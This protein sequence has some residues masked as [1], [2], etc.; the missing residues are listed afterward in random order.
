M[1]VAPLVVR[2]GLDDSAFRD[3]AATALV[4]HAL[5]LGF[6]LQQTSDLLLDGSQVPT[7]N[8]VSLSAIL[9][10]GVRHLEKRANVVEVKAKAAGMADEGQPVNISSLI[11][12][13]VS[14]GPCGSGQKADPLIVA[15]RFDVGAGA[16]RQLPNLHLTGPS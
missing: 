1:P 10:R 7:R 4:D 14:A 12:S 8:T 16:A 11:V 15:D 5:E 6:K 2:Q 3:M 13:V 9:L